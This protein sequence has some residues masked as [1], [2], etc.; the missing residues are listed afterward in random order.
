MSNQSTSLVRRDTVAELLKYGGSFKDKMLIARTAADGVR[1]RAAA[2][3]VVH[4]RVRLAHSEIAT[5]LAYVAPVIERFFDAVS[6]GKSNFKVEELSKL[7]G[8]EEQE[9]LLKIVAAAALAAQIGLQLHNSAVDATS[10]INSVD[11]NASTYEADEGTHYQEMTHT[12]LV[13][14]LESVSLAAGFLGQQGTIEIADDA[15]TRLPLTRSSLSHVVTLA[16]EFFSGQ[17][18]ASRGPPPKKALPP[19]SSSS[20]KPQA[21]TMNRAGGSS[22]DGT[23]AV[24][25]QAP[26]WMQRKA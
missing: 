20:A 19:P 22:K 2:S 21:S 6:D 13:N 15:Y 3:A 14:K 4:E 7:H 24:K 11:R 23:I 25:Q 10:I 8:V 12:D 17:G 18:D 1:D 26:D 16:D 5:A 9:Y